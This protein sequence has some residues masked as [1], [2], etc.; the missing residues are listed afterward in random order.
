MPVL[1][2]AHEKDG[3]HSCLPR[4]A[5]IADG[6]DLHRISD[7]E[8]RHLQD[9]YISAM[10]WQHP[11]GKAFDRWEVSAIAGC[12]FP[13][14]GG[15]DVLLRDNMSLP[16]GPPHRLVLV[17]ILA[18]GNWNSPHAGLM[19]ALGHGTALY[20]ACRMEGAGPYQDVPLLDDLDHPD[21]LGN[22]TLAMK[23]IALPNL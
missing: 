11:S 10:R 15:L 17:H 18:P 12:F 3:R 14:A 20:M 9:T 16:P 1:E 23:A 19:N 22:P 2:V 4:N 6:N 21:A 13:W 5:F 7:Q 8:R